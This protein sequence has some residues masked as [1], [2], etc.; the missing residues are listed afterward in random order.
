MSS[1]WAPC[2][3]GSDADRCTPPPAGPSKMGLSRSR[4]GAPKHYGK[5]HGASV[6]RLSNTDTCIN[7]LV[8]NPQLGKLPERHEQATSGIRIGHPQRKSIV[9]FPA[10]SCRSIIDTTTRGDAGDLHEGALAAVNTVRPFSRFFALPP[11]PHSI[12][13]PKIPRLTALVS[14]LASVRRFSGL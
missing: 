10:A 5:Q 1:D 8:T 2:I 12:R 14:Q 11:S 13:Q 4:A 6:F 3:T 7:H 9:N